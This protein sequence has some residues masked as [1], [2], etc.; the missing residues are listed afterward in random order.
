MWQQLI[1]LNVY[2]AKDLARF[3][4]SPSTDEQ[5]LNARSDSAGPASKVHIMVNVGALS[6]VKHG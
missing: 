1:Q 6:A 2:F 3:L 5:R 4:V